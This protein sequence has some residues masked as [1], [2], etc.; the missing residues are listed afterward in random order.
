MIGQ[1]QNFSRI[2]QRFGRHASAQDAQAAQFFGP[3]DKNSF[4][5]SSRGGPGGGETAAP[6][7][8]DCHIKIVGWRVVAHPITM[9]EAFSDGK[10]CGMPVVLGW[11]SVRV[12]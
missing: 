6:S 1:V 2:Q 10:P 4:E 12:L 3:I 11:Q 8:D 7:S 9:R 5:S